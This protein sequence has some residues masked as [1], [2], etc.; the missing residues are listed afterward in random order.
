MLA[1][2]ISRKTEGFVDPG[3]MILG[4]A[5]FTR[6]QKNLSISMSFSRPSLKV[7]PL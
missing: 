5:T 6:S 1:T 2:M 4:V 3:I 7:W